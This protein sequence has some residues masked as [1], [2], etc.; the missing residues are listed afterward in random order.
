[1]TLNGV[2]LAWYLFLNISFPFSFLKFEFCNLIAGSTEA[3]V[4]SKPW[5]FL[6]IKWKYSYEIVEDKKCLNFYT[7][8]LHTDSHMGLVKCFCKEGIILGCRDGFVVKSTG[9]FFRDP[10]FL[11]F[12][13]LFTIVC[14]SSSKG[15]N[16]LSWPPLVLGMH[17]V[18][19]HT[20]R[21][22]SI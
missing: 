13:L 22:K 18:H 8:C 2:F 4:Y 5:F 10:G 7:R 20:F 1:M 19:R 12:M 15:S 16:T 6:L 9:C 11:S 17:M 21:Q 3:I 14:N